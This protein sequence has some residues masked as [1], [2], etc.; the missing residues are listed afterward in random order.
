MNNLNM[1]NNQMM[2]NNMGQNM[3][4]NNG[5]MMNNNMGQNMMNNN[6]GQNMMNNNRMMMNNNGMMN[7]NNMGQNVMNNNGMMNS[8]NM[9]QN[10]MNNNGM[11]NSNNMGQNMMNNNGMMMNSNNMGQ[12]MMNNNGMI[13][14]NNMGQNMTNSNGMMNNNNMG[15]NMT[16]SNEM[17]NNNNMEQNLSPA[18]LTR[19]TKEFKLCKEDNDL[20]QIGCNFGLENENISTW[21]VTMV[22]PR[23]TP[24][25]G[26]LFTIVITFPPNYPNL[27]PEFKF[28]N[29]I[30]HLNV[31][32]TKN[33]DF[34]HICINSLNEW[35]TTGKVSGK[36]GYAVK[37]ALFDIFCLFYNQGIDSPYSPQMALDYQKNPEKFNEEAK[38]WTKQYA[39]LC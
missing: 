38:R 7:S 5:M 35:R 11:M 31:D 16:N 3:M 9:G 39:P 14:N 6:M 19:L 4:N 13:N 2:M 10:M 29:K 26:G 20:I 30:Y 23:T 36:P 15:Q 18:T 33:G 27:G 24:Y 34:G 8:N 17:I 22:G 25:E 32:C 28:K 37:Q 1:M 12:N 21:R